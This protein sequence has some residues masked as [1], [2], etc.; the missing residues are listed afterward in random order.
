MH[1]LTLR[2][3]VAPWRVRSTAQIPAERDSAFPGLQQI[4]QIHRHRM[5]KRT[6]AISEETHLAITSLSPAQ[7]LPLLA[8]AV[9]IGL[10][11]TSSITNGTPSLLRMLVAPAKRPRPWRPYATSSWASFTSSTD[12]SFA[13][14]VAFPSNLCPCFAGSMVVYDKSLS[15]IPLS[16]HHFLSPGSRSSLL[17]A[18]ACSRQGGGPWARAI[19]AKRKRL[20]RSGYATTSGNQPLPRSTAP[21]RAPSPRAKAKAIP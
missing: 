13:A 6:G 1:M 15:P 3:A 19:R 2:H 5:H 9:T 7:E 21:R 20:C 18:T 8:S 4:V 16:S 17:S 14:F 10:S 12:P 11:R